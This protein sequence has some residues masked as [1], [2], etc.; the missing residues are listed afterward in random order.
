MRMRIARE[1]SFQGGEG[2]WVEADVGEDLAEVGWSAKVDKGFFL[3]ETV[4]GGLWHE[5]V[6]RKAQ[7]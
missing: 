4:N 5:E 1:G 7:V 2:I 3:K 6:I